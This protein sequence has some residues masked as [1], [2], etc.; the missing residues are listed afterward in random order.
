MIDGVFLVDVAG[1]V[2][3]MDN[4][5][6]GRHAGT[7][8]RLG[9]A[10]ADREHHV[11]LRHPVGVHLRPRTGR[12]A[13]R[14]RVALGD[15][16]LAGIGCGDRGRN[17]LGKRREPVARLG[18]DHAGAGKNHR[19]LRR[20]QHLCGLFHRVGV[21]RDALDRDGL[22]IELALE[23]GVVHLVRDFDQRRAGLARA[24]GVVSAAHQIGQ[25]LDIMGER[26]PL[27][28]GAV[29]VSGAEHWAQVLPRQRQAA[30]HDQERHVLRIGLGHARI[31]VLDAGAGLGREHAV[32]LA[33]LDAAIA[34]GEA[35]ADALLAAQDRPDAERGAR[36]DDL[37]ARI[38][39]QEFRA[40]AL[41]D[42]GDDLCAFH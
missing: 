36:L 3:R 41:E 16:A 25:L 32:L 13:E 5:L 35:D 15:G 39:R 4:S 18:V 9:Q 14:Q 30:R 37:V 31:R 34:V 33:A 11:G 7:E 26:R 24:H 38:A 1:V 6:A 19:V 2:G 40:L 23:L 28:H 29:G 20:E 8:W 27:R 21:G 17:E 12:S 42:F 10:R 22:V